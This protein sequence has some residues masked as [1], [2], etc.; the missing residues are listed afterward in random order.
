MSDFTNGRPRHPRQ[1]TASSE[2]IVT[3]IGAAGLVAMSGYGP[4]NGNDDVDV[5][6]AFIF[7]VCD[8]DDG[9][10]GFD[11]LPEAPSDG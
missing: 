11:V 5:V 7:D 2:T 6:A 4:S 8:T 9:V 3:L 1:W 10:W